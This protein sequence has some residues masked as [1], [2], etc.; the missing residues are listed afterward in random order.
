MCKK[1]FYPGLLAKSRR[2]LLT[3]HIG[4]MTFDCRAQMEI[5]AA[6]EA[7]R[8]CTGQILISQVPNFEYELQ[9]LGT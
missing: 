3:S 2:C 4:L 9:G 5:V 1:E 6:K 7:V 8:F